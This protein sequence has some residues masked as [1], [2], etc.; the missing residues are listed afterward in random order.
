[1]RTLR[2]IRTSCLFVRSHYDHFLEGTRLSP[3][4]GEAYYDSLEPRERPSFSPYFDVQFYL[5]KNPDVY[6]SG[7]DPFLHFIRHGIYENRA[8]HPLISLVWLYDIFGITKGARPHEELVE[9]IENSLATTHPIIDLSL[10]VENNRSISSQNV[11]SWVFLTSDNKIIKTHKLFEPVFYQEKVNMLFNSTREAISHF[12]KY[13]DVN[14]I[15]PSDQFDSRWYKAEYLA[16]N[17]CKHGPFEH[18][19]F[20]G[21][22]HHHQTLPPKR[23]QNGEQISV[24][25]CIGYS[26]KYWGFMDRV[27]AEWRRDVES[28]D[29]QNPNL[30]RVEH[31]N[32]HH[33]LSTISFPLQ[34]KVLISIIMPM[35]N[36]ALQT[37]ECLLSLI[38]SGTTT[39][40]EVIIADDCSPDVSAKLIGKI[41][42]IK[43][44]RQKKNVGFLHNCN[45]ALQEARGEIILLL[46]NDTQ[47]MP[48][49]IDNMY[50]SLIKDS[51]VGAVCPKILYPNGRLQEA[52]SA[53]RFDGSTIMVGVHENPDSLCYS[54]DRLVQAS[55]GAALMFHR[56]LVENSIFD[57]RY[58]PAYCE[59]IDLCLRISALGYKIKYV[60]SAE[61]VHHL[62]LS[63]SAPSQ[64][65]AANV[66]DNTQRLSEKWRDYLFEINK[67]RAIAFYLPQFHPIPENDQWWGKGF[68]EWT[69]VVR[70]TPQFEGH[71]QPHIPADLGFYDLR[72]PETISEQAK[73]ASRYGIHGFCFYYYRFGERRILEKPLDVLLN[74]KG[75]N[76]KYCICWANENWTR[77]WDGKD[78]S[79][80]LSQIYTDRCAHLI[81]KDIA[82]YASD[83]RYIKVSNIPFFAIYRPLSIPRCAEFI[84]KVREYYYSIT[85]QEIYIAAV[86]DSSLL[87]KLNDGDSF[88]VDAF[89]EFPPHG[90]S[91]KTKEN[92]LLKGSSRLYDFTETA[93]LKVNDKNNFYKKFP[94][95]FCS[96]D[97]SA[98]RNN[99]SDIFINSSPAIFQGFTEKKLE[100]V[101]KFL[102]GDER[103]IFINAWNEWAEGA[104][105]EPDQH[106]GHQWL[107]AFRTALIKISGSM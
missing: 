42:G 17:E 56:R 30:A 104:H 57:S 60:S 70:A 67:I 96:W 78:S 46:N 45:K 22:A 105:L 55:S 51:K 76:A 100:E 99:D 61:V 86:L 44:V 39:P 102:V 48:N 5:D 38:R 65:K 84:M 41:P 50:F 85:R 66:L 28:C 29:L 79:V 14:L 37:T 21:Q 106:F 72:L 88:G 3:D 63:M 90:G 33:E 25:D 16:V 40:Y 83:D 107:E 49:S 23:V 98:R 87:A 24:A 18:Y 71:Y 32:L 31:N 91:V 77:R 9:I 15:S 10:C 27:H 36:F 64:Q 69:N 93:V 34:K 80:L 8:P 13:G 2:E 58:A 6:A 47:V 7:M 89:I 74:N 54:Y 73:L 75:I 92:R 43:Y 94:G 35:Y 82:L 26:A 52:G 19:L 95:L 11:L 81:S 62:S 97:N 68:T 12:L 103:L 20:F 101:C 59:D 1:M 4:D 53:V